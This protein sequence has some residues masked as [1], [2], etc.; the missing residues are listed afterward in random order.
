MKKT[1]TLIC[2]L[3]L[4]LSAT[5]FCFT[6]CQKTVDPGEAVAESVVLGIHN[7]FPGIGTNAQTIYDHVYSTCLNYGE[8]SYVIVE[9]DPG[10]TQ[11]FPI[12]KSD[13]DLSKAKEKEIAKRNA[14]NI[15]QGFASLKAQTPEVDT[16]S[17]IK[18]SANILKSS[19][20]SGKYMLV[21]DSGLC[22]KGLLSQLSANVLGSDPVIVVDKL[23]AVHAL[24][25][26]TGISVNWV[27]L[28]CVCGDQQKLPDSYFYNL[29]ALWTEIITRSGGTV[30]FDS[31]P[32]T[33]QQAN[34][35]PHVTPVSFPQDSLGLEDV[36]F[37][38]GPVICFGEDSIRFVGDEANFIDPEEAI[39]SLEP[40]SEY[41]IENPDR[42]IIIAGTT[43]K[44]GTGNGIELSLKRT[45]AVM[46]VLI[47]K[48][49]N[50]SQIECIGLGCSDN[51]FRVEDHNADGSFNEEMG[52]RNRAIY[53]V[54]AN[55]TVAN[56]LR[57]MVA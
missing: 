31:S 19:I 57:E 34:D 43:A 50:Q 37:D 8:V 29:K 46:N 36:D 6:A 1:V 12:V 14:T 24:P 21:Y 15:I 39:R 5:L 45:R 9:G 53:I 22:T 13:K 20:L 17:S 18:L 40:V 52:A 56:S 54:L 26:L 27:G 10:Q 48:G 3:S 2:I 55:S 11:T 30:T 49:V 47:E 7:N 42:K 51:C 23:E 16:L 32:V 38:D 44:V 41:L 4:L 25:D 33:G 28:G 35:L